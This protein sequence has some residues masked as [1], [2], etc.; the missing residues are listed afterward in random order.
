MALKTLDSII[1][2]TMMIG[3]ASSFKER[4]TNELTDFIAHRVMILQNKIH[5]QKRL[6]A[7]VQ[8]KVLIE[9][10]EMIFLKQEEPESLSMCFSC[11]RLTS[12]G[13]LCESCT[14]DHLKLVIE[15][16]NRNER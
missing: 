12:N 3:P 14:Q 9:L 8:E 2:Q 16:L 10:F 4:L 5:K 1:K 13:S 11:K 7:D 6:N 15:D